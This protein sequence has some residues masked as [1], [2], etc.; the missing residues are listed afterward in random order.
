MINEY[1]L[2]WYSRNKMNYQVKNCP[3]ARDCFS[4]EEKPKDRGGPK[5]TPLQ[6]E[7]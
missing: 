3:K 1:I 7:S 4:N 5:Q 2:K 6:V